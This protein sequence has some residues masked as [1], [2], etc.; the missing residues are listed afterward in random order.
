MAG[1]VFDKAVFSFTA[2]AGD[3]SPQPYYIVTLQNV[4]LSAFT[5]SFRG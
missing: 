1:K 5:P 4:S 3:V 2:P